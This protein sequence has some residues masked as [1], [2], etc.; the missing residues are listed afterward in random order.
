MSSVAYRGGS[1]HFFGIRISPVSD[2]L[3][4]GIFGRYPSL[5]PFSKRGWGP[6]KGG[7]CPPFEEKGGRCPLFDT[8]MYHR[9]FRRY[10]YGKY[11]EILTDTDRKIPI[12]YATLEMSSIVS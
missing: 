1:S 7:H 12:W 2:W 3:G 11:Q 9:V 5:P 4:I 6:Q 8:E 10:R